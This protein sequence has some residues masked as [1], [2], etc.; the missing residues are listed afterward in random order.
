MPLSRTAQSAGAIR[1]G[2]LPR[3]RDGERHECFSDE[4]SEPGHELRFRSLFHPGRGLSFDC[5]PDGNVDLDAL[6]ERA[7]Q[8]YLYAR[9]VIGCEFFIPVVRLRD[10]H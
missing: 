6:S 9:T 1:V 2:Q 3:C 10:P 7:L 4:S 8:N 5:D